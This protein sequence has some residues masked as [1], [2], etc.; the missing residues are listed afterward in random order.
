MNEKF[1]PKVGHKGATP[2]QAIGTVLSVD[3]NGYIKSE[4]F[5][6]K[7]PADW[8]LIIDDIVKAYTKNIPDQVH[9]IYVKG[10]VGRG[11]PIENVSDIDCVTL[12]TGSV[13]ELNLSWM[14]DLQK[15]LKEKYPFCA[16]FDLPHKNVEDIVSGRNK[17][18]PVLLKT[19][20][21]CVYGD[22][23]IPDLPKVKP[24]KDSLIASRNY[25][26]FINK[27]LDLFASGEVENVKRQ[28]KVIMKRILRAGFELVMERDQ[29]FTRDLYP[30]YKIFS[31]YYPEKEE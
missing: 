9:S 28:C 10:S 26:D 14:P 12:V 21:V 18:A 1:E 6:E 2:I 23:I 5:V 22:N 25:G 15:T 11:T 8:R 17:I 3:E 4:S 24:G 30:C 7:I 31:K 13:D 20:A 16:D 27:K 29:T 19:M